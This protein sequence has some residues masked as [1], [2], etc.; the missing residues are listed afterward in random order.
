MLDEKASGTPDWLVIR[1]QLVLKAV[2][3]GDTDLLRRISALPGG[4][5]SDTARRKAW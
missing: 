5:G 4:F 1:D 3:E 2:E